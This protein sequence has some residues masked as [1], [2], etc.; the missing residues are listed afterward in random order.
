MRTDVEEIDGRD[1]TGRST[2]RLNGAGG[3]AALVFVFISGRMM[4]KG[5]RVMNN[6]QLIRL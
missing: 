5:N 3:S 4:R 6:E 1:K 2:T